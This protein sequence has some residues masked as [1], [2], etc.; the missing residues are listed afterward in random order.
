MEQRRLA[1][2]MFTDIVGYTSLMAGDEAR[3]LEIV[4]SHRNTLLPLIEKH[5]GNLLKEMG[6]GTLTSFPSTLQATRCAIEIQNTLKSVDEFKIRIG[7]HLG[8]VVFTDTDVFGD[9]V[10]IAS[11]IETTAAA[12][13]ISISGQVA[14]TLSSNKEIELRYLGE[15]ELKNVTRPLRI[16]AIVNSGFPSPA[17]FPDISPQTTT[18]KPDNFPFAAKIASVAAGVLVIALLIYFTGEQPDSIDTQQAVTI[19]IPDN[20]T[21]DNGSIADAS[22][23]TIPDER[24]TEVEPAAISSQVLPETTASEPEPE[25]A[26]SAA[27]PAVPSSDSTAAFN[28]PPPVATDAIDTVPDSPAGPSDDSV[29]AVSVAPVTNQQASAT[30]LT[31]E[32]QAAIATPDSVVEDLTSIAILP[33]ANLSS[34]PDNAFFA[35]GVH[36]EILN[37]LAKIADI[38]VL[39]RRSVL[40]FEDTTESISEIANELGVATI[41]EGSVRFSGNRVRITCQLIRASDESHLWSETYERELE[42]IFE[43]QSDVALR[44]ANA[45]Q[46]SL[47]PAEIEYIGRIP[48]HSTEAYNLVLRANY[49]AEENNFGF[50]NEGDGWVAASIADLQRAI[51]LDENYAH[52][53]ATLA[54]IQAFAVFNNILQRNPALEAEARANASRAIELDGDNSFPYAVLAILSALERDWSAFDQYAEQALTAK[55]LP[56]GATSYLALA[57]SMQLRYDEAFSMVDRSVQVAPNAVEVRRVETITSILGRDYPRALDAAETFRALGGEANAYN[58]YKSAAYHFM[59]RADDVTQSLDQIT[60]ALVNEDFFFYPFYAYLSCIHGRQQ[61]VQSIILQQVLLN[62]TML[63]IGCEV[64]RDN[65][66]PVFALLGPLMESGVS[67]PDFGEAG[68]GFRA[69]PRYAQVEEYLNLR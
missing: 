63:T 47:L 3:A 20:P 16:Y 41:M 6:D 7:I 44:A 22:V 21:A 38:R 5:G 1:A 10:N 61:A 18:P 67:I 54:Y 37:Q 66:D 46:A 35:A 12:G 30:P 11:R 19:D 23:V 26:I 2:I 33:L 45:M 17:P 65:Y 48:T 9:G 34:D 52:A 4:A 39:S 8:D 58:L 15:K 28:E 59:G 14:D 43:I 64:G 32:V 42:D 69:D 60:G 27:E 56:D 62:R 29:V 57:Y 13:G 50:T 53:H 24:E 25:V 55:F 36:E 51:E 40:K 31:T 49:R 68:D